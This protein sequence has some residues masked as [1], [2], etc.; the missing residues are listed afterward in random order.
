MKHFEQCPVKIVKYGYEFQYLPN[1]VL[2]NVKA[3]CKIRQMSGICIGKRRVS[4][5]HS[6]KK[7]ILSSFLKGYSPGHDGHAF[8]DVIN[9]IDWY[10][11]NYL[12]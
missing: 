1:N 4:Y 11:Y 2:K 9:N 6:S 10:E 12:I 7:N 3:H 5:R 8:N